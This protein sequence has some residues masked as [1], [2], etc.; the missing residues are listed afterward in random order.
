MP[1]QIATQAVED[2]NPFH[3]AAQQFDRAAA[4]LPGA[5][6][7][8]INFLKRPVRAVI[9]EFPIELADGRSDE[10]LCPVC[11]SNFCIGDTHLTTTTSGARQLGKF[12]L[13]ER[14]GLGGFGAVWKA[15][16][17]ELDRLVALKLSHAGGWE[18]ESADLIAQFADA[19]G[20]SLSGAYDSAV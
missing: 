7:A 13:L 9:V 18:R 2:L 17:T 6:R 1:S 10:V 8:L 5:Q 19:H 3:I 14:V 20:N 11:G 16:D 4:Y 15:R 12:Q